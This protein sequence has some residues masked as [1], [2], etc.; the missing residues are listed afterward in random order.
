MSWSNFD[1]MMAAV[2][3]QEPRTIVVAA[4]AAPDVLEAVREAVR[5]GLG[6]AVPVVLT[7]RA[8]TPRSKLV[9]I[10]MALLSAR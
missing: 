3:A 6:A 1:A 8:D 10:A 9:S 5:L 7:S 4:A 2:R